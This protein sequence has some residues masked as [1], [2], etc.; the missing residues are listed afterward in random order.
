MFLILQNGVVEFSSGP[1]RSTDET[2]SICHW[3]LN[4]LLADNHNKLFLLRA[5]HTLQFIN[6][7]YSV[8]LRF[9]CNL[10]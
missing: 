8:D 1:R 6:L 5:G 4:S 3:N 10:M 9:Q 2:F 7:M